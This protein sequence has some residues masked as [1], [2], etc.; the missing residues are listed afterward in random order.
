MGLRYLRR[1][2]TGRSVDGRGRLSSVYCGDIENKDRA[3]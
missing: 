2:G 3:R 1:A